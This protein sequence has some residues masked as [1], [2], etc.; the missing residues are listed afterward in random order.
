MFGHVFL[1]ADGG[2]PGNDQDHAA[3]RRW[4]AKE[5]GTV[6]VSGKL[7]H[8]AEQGDGV[9][10]RIIATRRG[11]LGEWTAKH[12]T[13]ATSIEPFEVQPGDTIDFV[14]DC[15]TG[16]AHDTFHWTTTIRMVEP[17]RREWKSATGFHGPLPSPLDPWSR[18][19]QTLLLTNEFLFLD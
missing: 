18:Y 14:T 17:A 11:L 2:H 15:Q 5:A 9:R 1:N 8:P 4:T 7:E 16:P 12:Q 3:I 13:V 19:A 10:S 6:I